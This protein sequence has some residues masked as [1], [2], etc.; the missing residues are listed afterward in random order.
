MKD[1]AR[2]DFNTVGVTTSDSK[3]WNIPY[4]GAV[5][6]DNEYISAIIK[7]S[8]GKIKYYGKLGL[9]RA[10][11]SGSLP[12][13]EVN[14][15]GKIQAGDTLCVFNEQCNG[16][17]KTDLSSELVEVYTAPVPPTITAQPQNLKLTYGDTTGNTLSVEAKPQEH[18]ALS[19]QWYR[20]DSESAE[21]VVLDDGKTATYTV[22]T[23]QNVGTTK[24]YYCEVTVT[25]DLGS[26]SVS[27]TST[28][29]SAAVTVSKA[30]L[31]IT[32][33]DQ[34]YIYNGKMQGPGDLSTEDAD[35][36]SKYATV[37]GLVLGDKLKSITIDG[38]GQEIGEYP[39]HITGCMIEKK[40]INVKNNYD[41]TY[42][43]GKLHI[44]KKL[45][46]ITVKGSSSQKTYNGRKQTYTGKVS[47]SCSDEDFESLKFSYT[48]TLEVK[49]SDVGEYTEAIDSAECKYRDDNYDVKWK[50]ED[51]I[52]LTIE[53]APITIKADNKDCTALDKASP[54]TFTIK[55]KSGW[56]EAEDPDIAFDVVDGN[57][58]SINPKTAPEGKYNIVPRW[59]TENTNYDSTFENGIF[60]TTHDWKDATCTEPKTCKRCGKE[61]GNP[62]GHKYEE[63]KGSAK[64]ATCTEDGKEADQKCSGCGDV[65]EG[66]KID[67]LGHEYGAWTK[68]N[69]SQHQRVCTH[70]KTHV[71]KENHK[72]DA[73]K[74]TKRATCKEAGEKTFTCETCA[75]EKKETI[76]PTGHTEVIDKAVPATCTKTGLTEGKHCSV[77]NVVLVEQKT[78][79]ASGH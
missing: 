51:P 3:D 18:C 22:P 4:E 17:N 35:E 48:G 39:L 75:A 72:W 54:Y 31:T 74:V 41:I 52:K 57:G 30:K 29:V 63:V 68:L 59:G 78:V 15:D 77:C 50:V 62:L 64:A 40:G 79:P 14:T 66:A 61:S 53:K 71:E 37:S 11:D 70:D 25:R 58:K 33:R 43:E 27:E 55:D 23:D 38:Q 12:S 73:G 67:K 26:A 69:S 20:K 1:S 8:D 24:Y 19:Y 7:S 44:V 65:I 76:A 13:V 21:P 28:S 16:D 46:N 56:F 60:D 47:A 6:G 10:S 2:K 32:A 9:A 45:L 36:I 34:T 42:E 5:T 49:G